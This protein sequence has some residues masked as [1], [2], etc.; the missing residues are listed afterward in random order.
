MEEAANL[1]DEAL[2]LAPEQVDLYGLRGL[3]ALGAG[4]LEGAAATLERGEKVLQARGGPADPV[5]SALRKA[6]DKP[7]ELPEN[8]KPNLTVRTGVGP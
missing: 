7:F 6:L 3:A 1:L 4:D 5:L 8:F 2:V